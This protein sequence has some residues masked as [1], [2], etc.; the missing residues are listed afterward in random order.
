M[1]KLQHVQN[2]AVCLVTG[3]WKHEHGLS[4]LMHDDLCWLGY[5]SVMQY[6]LAVTVH[7][8]LRYLTD[9][10]VPVS[11]VAGHQH[12]WS[13]RCYQ[14]SV[15]QV[16]HRTFGPVH[17]LSPDQ[18]SGIHCLIICRIQLLI[19]NNLGEIWRCICSLGIR[20]VSALEVLR[21]R[22]LLIYL[23]KCW[24]NVDDL[25]WGNRRQNT[26]K[27]MLCVVFVVVSFWPAELLQA[28]YQCLSA[29]SLTPLCHCRKQY[30][31][32]L[33]EPSQ[34]PLQLV[35]DGLVAL[36]PAVSLRLPCRVVQSL[37]SLYIMWLVISV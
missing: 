18:E 24:Y 28:L 22:T 23:L 8:C 15:P 5:F 6:K 35:L 3:T 36:S 27:N 32:Q 19:P 16:C 20:S 33:L 34:S 11:E 37:S 25:Q 12:L 26:V 7:R 30:V 31:Q 17:F 29:V 21:N 2:A 1:D 13:A 4:R 10:C 14:L 9:Y